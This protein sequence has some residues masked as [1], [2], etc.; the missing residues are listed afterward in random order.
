MIEKR[1]QVEEEKSKEIRGNCSGK[2]LPLIF[3]WKEKVVEYMKI[4]IIDK[5]LTKMCCM[6]LYVQRNSWSMEEQCDGRMKYRR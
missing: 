1:R 6:L 4:K 3:N 5:E 2:A